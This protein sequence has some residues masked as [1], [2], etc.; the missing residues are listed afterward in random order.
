MREY[1]REIG[2]KFVESNGELYCCKGQSSEKAKSPNWGQT[3]ALESS[4][5]KHHLNAL[6]TQNWPSATWDNKVANCGVKNW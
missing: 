3:K 4:V 1:F 2:A 5:V 6:L